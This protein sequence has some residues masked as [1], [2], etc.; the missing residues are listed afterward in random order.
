[1]DTPIASLLYF[2]SMVQVAFT[3]FLV[4]GS[5]GFLSSLWFTRLIYSS[6]KVD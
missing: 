3:I 1:L 2:S 6:I 5:V 4:T